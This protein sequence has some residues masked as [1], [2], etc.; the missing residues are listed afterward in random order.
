MSG[1]LASEIVLTLDIDWA[2][3]FVIDDVAQLLVGSGVKATW[4]V[5]HPSPA[6]DRLRGRPDLFELGIHPNFFTRSSHGETPAA[7]LRSCLDLVPQAQSMRTHGLVQSTPLLDLAIESGLKIDVS[8]YVPHARQAR[9]IEY[10]RRGVRLIRIPYVWE[11]DFEMERP[12]PV[13]S[14]AELAARPGLQVMDF[15]PI[16]VWLNGADMGPYEELKRRCPRLESA[17]RADAAPLRRTGM[18]PG[19]MFNEAI[20]LLASNKTSRCVTELVS[21]SS[22]AAV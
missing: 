8:L 14:A 18:G 9:P 15:H 22:V 20:A 17:T 10:W 21:A 12:A 1:P 3:D 11:D 13:W 5:T 2:P 7:V 4:F 19:T 16:H 6:V